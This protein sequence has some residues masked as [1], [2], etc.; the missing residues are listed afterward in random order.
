MGHYQRR[1][2]FIP[3]EKN[4]RKL[5]S[6]SLQES[7]NFE[8]HNMLMAHLRI[9]FLFLRR[10]WNSD[11]TTVLNSHM[12][13]EMEGLWKAPG[14][15]SQLRLGDSKRPSIWNQN[16]GLLRPIWCSFLFI[17]FTAKKNEKKR[18]NKSVA[19]RHLQAYAES[20]IMCIGCKLHLI[21]QVGKKYNAFM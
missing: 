15:V 19:K 11:R 5:Q 1:S 7:R 4:V 16:L 8:V 10:F 21:T 9:I 14:P 3:S 12:S 20:L 18:K 13:R 6:I 2:R 17:L